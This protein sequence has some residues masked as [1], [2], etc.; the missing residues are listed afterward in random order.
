VQGSR[1]LPRRFPDRGEAIDFYLCRP[2]GFFTGGEVLQTSTLMAPRQLFMNIPFVPGLKRGQDFMWMIQAGSMGRADLHVVPEVL[3][4][5]NSE[6][7]TDS[8][9]VSSKPN[10]R[11]FYACVR[12]NRGLFQASTYSY[13]IATRILT[14]A[15]K[16]G[17][18]LSARF[19]LLG[20]CFS[21]GTFSIK[22]LILF[23]YICLIPTG[24]RSWLGDGLRSMNR[25]L[26]AGSSQ[27]GPA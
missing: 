17:E 6:G 9:R 2:R 10:W 11:S 22:C 3:S 24:T 21:H 12:A 26:D 25:R 5:F 20:G 8:K 1:V 7:Y 19:K 27:A 18:P 13:C 23:L 15:I 16:Y 14:D 4:I